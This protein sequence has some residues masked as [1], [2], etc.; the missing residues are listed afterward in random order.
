LLG[1]SPV[2]ADQAPDGLS[3]LDRHG[4]I[5]GRSGLAQGRSWL[6]RLVGPVAVVVPRVLVCR[7]KTRSP[8]LSWGFVIARLLSGTR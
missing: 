1:C 5:D 4:D 3:A 8:L 7:A 2:L 6:P